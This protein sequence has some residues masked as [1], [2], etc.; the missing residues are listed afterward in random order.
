MVKKNI[1]I[2]LDTGSISEIKSYSKKNLIKGFTSN[3]SLL[4][5]YNS[6][7]ILKFAKSACSFTNKPLSIEITELQHSKMID[8]ALLFSEISNNI[9][10]K[11]PFYDHKGKELIKIIKYL[12]SKRIKLNVTAVF[13]KRQINKLSF[14]LGRG[15]E[16]IVSIFAGRIADTLVSP[17]EIVKHAK[18]KLKSKILWASTREIYNI[19]DAQ[20]SGADIITITK[21]FLD[22][23]SMKNFSLEEYSK[24]T[25][26]QFFK[27]GQSLKY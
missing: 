14:V 20:N 27:D 13:S 12:H 23:L 17:T 21:G 18:A 10:I 24:L 26:K 19:K 22:K 2:Y 15:V 5:K 6:L 9:F 1:D 7:D 11:V 16:S 4:K 8:Q 3:P 25:S